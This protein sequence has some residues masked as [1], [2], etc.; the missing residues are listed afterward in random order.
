[1]GERISVKGR[2]KREEGEIGEGERERQKG[3]RG[4]RERSR[5]ERGGGE[6]EEKGSE[7]GNRE[8]EGEKGKVKRSREGNK[9]ERGKEDL[10]KA[11]KARWCSTVVLNETLL[12]TVLAKPYCRATLIQLTS[13]HLA[14]A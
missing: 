5:E 3:E 4:K 6:G 10:D 2:R 13:P 14:Q 9:R 8:K 7:K 11:T 12:I 1:M